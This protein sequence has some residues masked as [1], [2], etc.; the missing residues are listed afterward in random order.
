VNTSIVYHLW[1]K[2]DGKPPVEHPAR[3]QEA[4]RDAG[5]ARRELDR[6]RCA[7]PDKDW[8]VTAVR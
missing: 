8:W 2:A 1:E 3:T 4:V 6:R 5:A 7:E